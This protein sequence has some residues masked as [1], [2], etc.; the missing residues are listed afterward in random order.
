M[1]ISSDGLFTQS[2][3]QEGYTVYNV[4]TR[5]GRK[6]IAKGMNRI[7]ALMGENLGKIIENKFL[8]EGQELPT[9]RS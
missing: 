3:F 8:V 4:I 1:G 5:N 9:P 2:A 7:S 6:S